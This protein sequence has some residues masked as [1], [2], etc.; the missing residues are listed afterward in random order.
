[1]QQSN[2]FEDAG[3]ERVTWLASREAGLDRLRQFVPLAGSQ[4]ARTRNFD[5]GPDD[6][7]NISCLSP[8][9]R[10]RAVLEQEVLAQTLARFQPS[11]AEKFIQ[12]VYWRGYFKGWL[13]NRPSVWQHFCRD[14]ETLQRSID[15]D[16]TLRHGYRAAISGETGIDCFDHWAREL[17]E[18]N[19]LHNHARM[20]F[21][22]I[23]IFTLRLPWQLGAG[24]FLRHLLDGDPASNTL[25][26]RWVGGLHT[27]GKTYSARAENIHRFT[28][29]RFNPAGQL[30]NTATSI[31][32]DAEY[33]LVPLPVQAPW[34]EASRYGLLMTEED[35]HS[36]SLPLRDQP[37]AIAVLPAAA[38]C[39][40]VSFADDVMAFRKGLLEDAAQRAKEYFACP[41]QQLS[42]RSTKALLDWAQSEDLDTIVLSQPPVGPIRDWLA[43]VATEVA[44][45]ELS[46]AGIKC[47]TIL[48]DYDAQVWPHATA[49]F[50]KL[51]KRIPEL[52]G[53]IVP[54]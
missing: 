24:F 22:S 54:A 5:L 33:P 28:N 17:V 41:V 4:Y 45:S 19:Y 39:G 42:G 13:E 35:L 38:E 51:K 15:E 40:P 1:M 12:E 10:H 43:A 29:G 27:K 50:F 44:T 37:A 47:H 2:L 21:A 11:S 48:R 18:T 31:A 16:E 26:W 32:E 14:L 46:A 23:W 34:P 25:S 36:E 9:I 3:V 8:W 53:T 6:R 7:S 20:W 30:S 49:G 52:L